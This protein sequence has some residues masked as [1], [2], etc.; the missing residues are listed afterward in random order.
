MIKLTTPEI[1]DNKLKI[2]VPRKKHTYAVPHGMAFVS[3]ENKQV[4]A[5][6]G[7]RDYLQDIIRTY[8]NNKKRI[9]TDGHPY[10]P[11]LKDPD[12]CMD[13][14]RLMFCIKKPVL[15]GFI[16]SLKVLNGI[17]TYANMEKTIAEFVHL[18]D[19][20]TNDITILL[21]GSGE[22]MKNPHLLSLLT[23]IIR[24]CTY[25]PRFKFEQVSDLSRAFKSMEKRGTMKK[26]QHLMKECHEI[27]HEILKERK[28]IFKGCSS[29][30]LFPIDIKHSF[31]SKGGI[32]ELCKAN[33]P[34]KKV[35]KKI[36]ELKR[37]IVN[38]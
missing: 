1:M 36:V 23:L 20:S 2:E 11:E 17:E 24:F 9:E 15:K 10:Y 21:R 5:Y 3:A 38:I 4:C 7:C 32:F 13:R 31:H 29:K 8:L 35:N 14:L 28:D 6:V 37:K 33:S 25:N 27:L 19:S 12:L 22:Y 34:N 30:E 26:D 16:R 18:E